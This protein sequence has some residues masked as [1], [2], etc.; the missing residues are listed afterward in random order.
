MPAEFRTVE[1]NKTSLH[2]RSAGKGF[3]VILIHGF[4]E[5]SSVWNHQAE[6]LKDFC[7]VIIPDLPGTGLSH[8][9][10]ESAV[11][12]M[13]SMASDIQGLLDHENISSCLVFGHSMGG[14]ITLAF[15]ELFPQYL[16]GFGLVHSTAY[17][18]SE[19]KKKNRLRSME[20]IEEYGG[21]AFLKTTIPNLFGERFKE[22]ES[23]IIQDQINK[24]K[25]F[26]NRCLQQ[27]TNAMMLRK[28]RCNV[29]S[30]T[31]IPVLLVAG[32]EDIAAPLKD[33]QEQATLSAH[34]DL[35]ILEGVGHMGM[36]EATDQLNTCMLNFIQKNIQAVK[37]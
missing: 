12:T 27:Y 16:N 29:L 11:C 22:T 13:E 6:F 14:Y 32:T 2:Y 1:N 35:H 9:N 31:H 23:A 28:D 34:I 25:A 19:E 4:G 18:D 17:A 15:A 37:Y 21:Y 24:S 36:L 20:V 5:D 30:D 8:Y 7:R 33:I 10:Q 26:S 3:P